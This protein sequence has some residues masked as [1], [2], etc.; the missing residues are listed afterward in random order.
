MAAQHGCTIGQPA[1]I[2]LT[3]NRQYRVEDAS[4]TE[5]EDLTR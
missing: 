5:V 2:S 4:Y 3:C 1:A